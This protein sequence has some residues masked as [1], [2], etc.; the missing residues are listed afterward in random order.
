[1]VESRIGS[2]EGQQPDEPLQYLHL[3][4]QRRSNKLDKLGKECEM[5]YSRQK[6]DP[7]KEYGIYEE[8]YSVMFWRR[9][10]SRT[11]LR[12]HNCGFSFDQD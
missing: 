10:L 12:A 4:L 7:D 1:M 3:R 2:P 9:D 8:S 5:E 11:E 6:H